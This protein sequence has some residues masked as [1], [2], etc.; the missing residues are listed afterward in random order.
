MLKKMFTSTRIRQFKPGILIRKPRFLV[1]VVLKY[2]TSLFSKKAHP[3]RGVSLATTYKCNFLCSHCYAVRFKDTDE[4]PMTFE[5]KVAMINECRQM[6]A[7]SFD[8]VGGEV[9]VSS[10]FEALLP[11]TRPK[12]TY[13]SLA[14]NG[15]EMSR[16][17]VKQLKKAG[18]DKIS[19]SIDSG[20]EAQHDRFR[21]KKGSYKRCFEAIENIKAEGLTPV[22]TTTVCKGDTKKEEFQSLVDF[23]ISKKIQLVFSAS[24]P[25][26]QW[27]GDLDLL[28][29]EEDIAAM[30]ELHQKH[31]NLTRDIYENMGRTGCPAAKQT[32][33]IS[34][35]GDVMPCAFTHISFGNLKYESIHDIRNRAL[36]TKEFSGYHP[37]CFPAEDREFID[38]H[39]SKLFHSKTYPV[40]FREVFKGREG[41]DELPAYTLKINKRS[42]PCPS[43]GADEPV[44]VTAG[45]EHEFDNTT[46][47]LF[48]VVRCNRCN[49]VYLDPI[50]DESA[51]DIIYPA[52]YYCHGE[53]YIQ[54]K[55]GGGKTSPLVGIKRKLAGFFGYPRLVKKIMKK[56]RP[57]PGQPLHVLDVGCGNGA[58]LDEFRKRGEEHKIAT[59]TTGLDYSSRALELAAGRGHRTIQCNIDSP[60]EDD[61]GENK[62]H[63]I[64][65]SN[66]IEHVARPQW[67][68]EQ[69]YRALKPGGVFV[70]ETPNFGSLDAKIFAPSGH[71]GGFHFPRHW[72]FY[73]PK[74]FK[75]SAR[76]AG[77][78]VAKISFKP[79]PIFWFWTMHSRLYRGKGK[80]EMARRKYPLKEQKT[81]F[82]R[83]FTLKILFTLTDYVQLILARRTSLMVIRMIKQPSNPSDPSS[84]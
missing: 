67:M 57:Q 62:Y 40:S 39:L 55:T 16:Q 24:I 45:R 35:Y 42:R 15:Y 28:C 56:V 12:Q 22:I 6:G 27:E 23:A 81:G 10:D 82:L 48:Y 54:Q 47:D 14:S 79:V 31:P 19:I 61:L 2:V 70:C 44:F 52:D 51:L 76:R 68:L 60:D 32:L 80:K 84:N 11:H 5:E 33:Y 9:G 17:R 7:I 72:T 25:F 43:C 69:I 74:T 49:L 37:I 77:F 73:T 8:F 29:D 20:S 30:H 36:S 18:V 64:Y 75:R 66:V 71:W 53:S 3:L 34:E 41:V 4:A 50:P 46:S 13:I 1:R 63:I 21:N 83:S 38:K 65:S 78:R 59:V 26:G 58:A